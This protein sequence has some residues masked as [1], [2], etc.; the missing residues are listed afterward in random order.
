[1]EDHKFSKVSEDNLKGVHHDLCKVLRAAI[2]LSPIGFG[3][4]KGVIGKREQLELLAKGKS[5]I[6]DNR[7]ITGHAVDIFALSNNII[8]W[9]F[10]HYQAIANVILELSKT[11]GIEIEWGGNY[12]EI[13][14][15]VHFQLSTIS[16]P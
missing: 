11:M 4:S 5:L 6:S 15:A 12:D 2:E 7:H 3:I 10:R 16:Y 8:S 9:E 1:M 14:D 13:N